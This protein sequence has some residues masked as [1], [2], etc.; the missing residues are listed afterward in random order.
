MSKDAGQRK[1]MTAAN[2]DIIIC[3]IA[4]LCKLGNIC[5]RGRYWRV[6]RSFERLA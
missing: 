2:C 6:K 1:S 5:G 4:D 3:I